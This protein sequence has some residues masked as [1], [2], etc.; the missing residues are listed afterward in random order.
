VS[1]LWTPAPWRASTGNLVRV[2]TTSGAV[3]AGVHRQGRYTGE[4]IRGEVEANAH[5]ISAAPEMY[6]ALA[7]APRPDPGSF[8]LVA[9][10]DWYFH[11]RWAAIA[12][13]EGP[14]P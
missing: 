8:D 7:N 10:R 2:M 6:A 5:L 3:I 14:A 1:P 11:V 9:Y 4:V 13:A 12:K